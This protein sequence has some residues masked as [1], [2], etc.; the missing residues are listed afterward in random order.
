MFGEKIPQG[1]ELTKKIWFA[2]RDELQVGSQRAVAAGYIKPAGV[3]PYSKL[4]AG[5]N[6]KK[7]FPGFSKMDPPGR[8]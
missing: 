1:F 8:G 5:A 4:P 7:A 3:R 2:G 6:E